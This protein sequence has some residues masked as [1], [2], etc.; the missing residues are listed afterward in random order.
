MKVYINIKN[1]S[2]LR[3]HQILNKRIGLMKKE[4]KHNAAHRLSFGERFDEKILKIYCTDCH[5]VTLVIHQFI[6]FSYINKSAMETAAQCMPL[7]VYV[8]TRNHVST[9]VGHIIRTDEKRKA[10]DNRQHRRRGFW[11]TKSHS[12]LGC[13]LHAPFRSC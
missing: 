6:G 5:H 10:S 12:S 4:R 3:P 2:N 9:M 11:E 7:C 8:R 13:F 1:N